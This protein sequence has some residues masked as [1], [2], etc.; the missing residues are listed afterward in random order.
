MKHRLFTIGSIQISAL[1]ET[2]FQKMMGS[3]DWVLMNGQEVKGSKYAKLT[4][5]TTV[6]N[7]TGRFLRMSGGK[8]G[9]LLEPQDYSTAKPKKAF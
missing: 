5:K 7:A 3:D 8:A 6:P 9:P 4:N 2:Q 1:S